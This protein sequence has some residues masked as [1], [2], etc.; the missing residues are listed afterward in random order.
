MG[1]ILFFY[2]LIESFYLLLTALFRK[3]TTRELDLSLSNTGMR[4]SVAEYRASYDGSLRVNFSI[5]FFIPIVESFLRFTWCLLW[6]FLLYKF[7][8]SSLNYCKSLS[9]SSLIFWSYY[10]SFIFLYEC[11]IVWIIGYFLWLN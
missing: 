9:N 10:S 11:V 4:C 7:C 8:I 3:V 5:W 1:W 2:F 6:T